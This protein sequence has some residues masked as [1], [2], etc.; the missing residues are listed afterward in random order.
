[1]AAGPDITRLLVRW[2]AGDEDAL[3]DLMPLVYAELRRLARSY[4]RRERRDHTLQATALVHELFVRLAA[5]QPALNDRKHFF[6]V[7]AR[8]MQQI[9]VAHARKRDAQ[10]RGG[11]AERVPLE[12]ISAA[13]GPPEVDLHALDQAL[14]RLA[15]RDPLQAHI[16]ELRFFGGYTIEE[17]AAII[18]KSHAT[19]SR[20][21]EFARV[22]LYREISGGPGVA[23]A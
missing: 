10:K 9:L 19:V 7:A 13:A 17:T 8:A 18:K 22:W 21:W 20:E 1:M 2:R 23:R 5:E 6:G 12:D 14:S 4:L 11:D 16:V 15:E 3:A